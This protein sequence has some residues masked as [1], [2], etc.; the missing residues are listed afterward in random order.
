MGGLSNYRA[1][2]KFDVLEA[3]RNPIGAFDAEQFKKDAV[4]LF[5]NGSNHIVVDLG[6][7]DY[8]YSDSFNAFSMIHQKL[9]SRTG[10]LGILA[11]DELAVRSLQQAGVDR[12]VKV[13]RSEPELMSAT[14]Q[15][16][17]AAKPVAPVVDVAPTQPENA[18]QHSVPADSGARRTHKFTQSFNSTLNA[19]PEPV[20]L[21]GMGT[22]FDA[23]DG[24]K[25][26][27]GKLFV[28][29]GALLLVAAVVV[30]F[31]FLR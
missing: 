24:A 10:T 25:S 18:G 16:A 7:L 4:Q 12:Y 17:P 22:S 14:L 8:L 13:F 20:E 28:G 19:E 5:E 2:G 23:L 1:V 31:V 15:Q 3:P 6:N 26:S 21:K 9:V 29:V 27:S 30:Y 11:S